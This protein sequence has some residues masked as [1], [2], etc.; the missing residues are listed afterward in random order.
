MNS[1]VE[2]NLAMILLL[3]WYAILGYV[4]W[5]FPSQPRNPARR[6]FDL[7][8]L[9]MAFVLAIVSMQWS[10]HHATP[11]YGGMWKQVLATSV[12]YG[13]FLL[14][15]TVAT[16]AR[17]RIFGTGKRIVQTQESTDR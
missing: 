8:S 6:G 3:P 12:S 2:L 4:F 10:F 1:L 13:V 16:L 9:L 17:W 5:R 14:V 15:L 7:A 11:N